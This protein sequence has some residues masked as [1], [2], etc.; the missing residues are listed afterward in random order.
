MTAE[1]A[2]LD[3]VEETR[4]RSLASGTPRLYWI[5]AAA[6]LACI[7]VA[8]TDIALTFFPL[9]AGEPG[10]LSA[11]DWFALFNQSWFFGM[12][13][14]G[15]LP[16]MPTELLMIP[17]FLALYRA[18]RNTAKE[19]AALGM[20]LFLLGAAIYLSNNAAFPM[21]ALSTRY[22]AAGSDAQRALLAA[23]GEAVLARGEDFTPGSFT[24]FVLGEMA[25][26]SISLAMLRGHI[27][28]SITALMGILAGLLLT[29]STIWMT[30]LPG[31]TQTGILV[32]MLGGLA[33]IAWYILT[34]RRL[35]QLRLP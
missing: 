26:L 13:N 19:Y 31:S 34:A 3:R 16:N 33:S 7:V 2:I 17:L 24:G 12:R 25:I 23:A 9:G 32:A 18:H 29:I 21:L 11:V 15:L 6:A 20:V 14:L 10:T 28:S 4:T 8:L 22:S 1:T 35:L 5:A 30:F 27:F